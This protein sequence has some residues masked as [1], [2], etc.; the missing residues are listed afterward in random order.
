MD[1]KYDIITIGSATRD[2]YLEGD[3]FI[4]VV[5][6][7]FGTGAGICV[8]LGSKVDV[9]KLH[10]TTG[11]SALNAA[12]TFA[13]QD[14]KTAIIAKLG[15][16]EHAQSIRKRM[17]EEGIADELL[18]EDANELTA[19]SVLIHS[20]DGERSIFVYRGASS[21]LTPEEVNV[22]EVLSRTKWIYMTHMAEASQ[23]VFEQV[24]A[25]ASEAGVKIAINPG[26]TQLNMG[27]A[28]V[29]FLKNVSILFVNQEEAAK[30]T[31]TD[32]KNENEVFA[33][34]DEWIEGIVVMTKGKDG[35]TVSDGAKHYSAGI[36]PDTG[37]VDRTGAGDAFGSGFTSVIAKGGT[38]EEAIQ[39]GSAN[40]TGVITQ[41]GANQGLLAKTDRADKYGVLDIKVTPLS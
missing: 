6:K 30:L 15:R 27:E 4:P 10:L 5:D 3:A 40:A 26:S 34:L 29:P 31:G 12:V 41:W 14:L 18:Q 2:I 32:Y 24:M 33:K 9:T 19:T 22:P 38:I 11:G 28:F 20:P 7:S 35:V 37:L 36:L 25:G 16:D 21:H 39:L 13:R 1:T 23:E 8:N 17:A